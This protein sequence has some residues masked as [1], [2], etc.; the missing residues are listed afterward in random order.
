MKN[1]NVQTGI[2][3]AKYL[4]NHHDGV[5]THSD[6]SKFYDVSIFKNKKALNAFTKELIV[7]GYL[8][9]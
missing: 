4:V 6:G 8:E 3:K 5:K 2:G 9:K 1:F 7:K